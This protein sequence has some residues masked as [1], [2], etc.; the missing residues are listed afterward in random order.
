MNDQPNPLATP[1]IVATL[2]AL[3]EALRAGTRDPTDEQQIAKVASTFFDTYWAEVRA[4]GL[5]RPPYN[6]PPLPALV[7]L[8]QEC[9][10]RGRSGDLD[11]VKARDYFAATKTVRDFAVWR[12][13]QHA[14]LN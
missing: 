4:R 11:D 14:K 5:D 8:E 9:V 6:W 12:Q 3:V 7:V 1:E 2:D 10:S 13:Q